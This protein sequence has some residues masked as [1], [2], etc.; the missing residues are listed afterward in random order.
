MEVKPVMEDRTWHLAPEG[1]VQLTLLVS[2]SKLKQYLWMEVAGVHY[3][4]SLA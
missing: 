4:V 2:W 3:R 1:L